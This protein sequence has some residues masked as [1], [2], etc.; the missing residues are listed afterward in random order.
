MQFAVSTEHLEIHSKRK[1]WQVLVSGERIEKFVGHENEGD[2]NC[3][4]CAQNGT[5]RLGKVWGLDE[6]EI[7]GP[8]KT[9]FTTRLL[10]SARILRRI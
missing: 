5:Q 8:I 2:N 10:R 9:I 3:N 4:W 6:L 7:G 1:E